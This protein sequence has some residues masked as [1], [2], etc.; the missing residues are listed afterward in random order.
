LIDQN[1]SYCSVKDSEIAEL[2]EKLAI[3]NVKIQNST[4]AMEEK[5]KQNFEL[6]SKL[7]A[8]QSKIRDLT[9]DLETMKGERD[10]ARA[11]V[12]SLTN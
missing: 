6:Q 1:I 9:S 3:E 4:K 10:A 12:D 8:S 5:N 2:R 7:T 11:E